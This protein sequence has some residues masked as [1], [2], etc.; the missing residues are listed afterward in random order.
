MQMPVG[1]YGMSS[2]GGSS[3]G[4]ANT[5]GSNGYANSGSG[6]NGNSGNTRNPDRTPQTETVE[7]IDKAPEGNPHNSCRRIISEHLTN[8][9]KSHK[10]AGCLQTGIK[11]RITKY[12]L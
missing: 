5:S 1:S 7:V 4:Y 10:N 11:L 9:F 2:P 8:P 12:E 6:G 3:G